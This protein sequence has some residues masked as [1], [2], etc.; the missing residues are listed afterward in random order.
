MNHRVR[1][2]LLALLAFA[3]AP[4]LAA[5]APVTITLDTLRPAVAAG[6]VDGEKPMAP[7]DPFVA[8]GTFSVDVSATG[9]ARLAW[10][11]GAAALLEPST[12]AIAGPE[13]LTVKRGESWLRFRK[14]G[15]AFRILTPT[16]TLCIRGTAFRLLVDEAGG[17]VVDL[18][19]GRVE[20]EAGGATVD[21]V[22]GQT[23]RVEP[24]GGAPVV[25]GMDAAARGRIAGALDEMLPMAP[26]ADDGRGVDLDPRVK[27]P[28]VSPKFDRLLRRE[29]KPKGDQNGAKVEE[30]PAEK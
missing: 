17:T 25:A 29:Q 12:R 22:A 10:S 11:D 26:A 5:D 24:Q 27:M 20:V 9:L 7:G 3:A 4:C 15:G 23:A 30:V 14:R 2:I 21:L 1:M 19:E 6:A 8:A 18:V 28:E 13:T 16:A